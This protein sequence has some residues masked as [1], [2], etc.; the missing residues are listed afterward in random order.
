MDCLDAA[1]IVPLPHSM[2]TCPLRESVSLR[3]SRS[4]GRDPVTSMLFKPERP[5]EA[6]AELVHSGFL[7]ADCVIGWQC[8]EAR[9][10]EKYLVA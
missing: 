3:E 2:P 5:C 4:P 6:R 1:L 10:P 9:L 8:P 7:E